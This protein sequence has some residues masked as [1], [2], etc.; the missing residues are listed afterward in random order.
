MLARSETTQEGTEGATFEEQAG[1]IQDALNAA[2]GDVG[3]FRCG[4]GQKIQC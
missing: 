4:Y 2:L 3:K 1:L